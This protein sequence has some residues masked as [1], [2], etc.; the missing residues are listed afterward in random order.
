ME[1]VREGGS[2]GTNDSVVVLQE[3]KLQGKGFKNMDLTTANIM[4]T[5]P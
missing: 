3:F 2:R 4:T 5:D 1:V